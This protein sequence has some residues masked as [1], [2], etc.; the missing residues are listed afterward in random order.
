MAG[1]TDQTLVDNILTNMLHNSTVST[2]TA[3]TGGTTF[4]IT[5]PI[6][7]RLYSATGSETA[8]GTQLVAGTSPGY[9]ANGLTM[10]TNA[11]AAFSSGA[12]TNSN[13]VQFT[14]SGTWS[15]GV[16]ALELWSSDGTP[17]RI[18]WGALTTT[19][20]ANAVTNGDTVT[21]A[22]ASISA[23]AATW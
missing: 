20:I 22:V 14:A 17:V 18:L 16:T 6:M 10:G 11:F 8:T 12:A 15:L 23:S 7:L 1:M 21:F 5:P 3:G 4:T 13:Q 19:I 9:V 2:F